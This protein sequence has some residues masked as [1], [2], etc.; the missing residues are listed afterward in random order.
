MIV[1]VLVG[2]HNLDIEWP[3]FFISMLVG[4]FGGGVLVLSNQQPEIKISARQGFILVLLCWILLPCYAALPF[5]F[6]SRGISLANSLFES[7]SGLTTTGTTIF[8]D[9]ESLS[10]ALL[11]W[12]AILQWLG[13]IGII[14]MAFTVMPALRI[15]GMQLFLDAV[16]KADK[17]GAQP[18]RQIRMLA[19]IYCA[20]TFLCALCYYLSGMGVFDAVS[21]AMTT[22]STGGFSNYNNSIAHFSNPFI[23]IT[24]LIFM[25]V[26]SLPFVL[27]IRALSGNPAGFWRDTQSLWFLG[28][29]AL[30]TLLIAIDIPGWT[31]NI[32]GAVHQAGFTTISFLS[33]TGFMISDYRVWSPATTAILFFMTFSGGC[34]GSTSGGIK[35]FRFQILYATVVTQMQKLLYPSG[36]FTPRFQGTA[37]TPAVS[38]SVL[39][40]FFAYTIS[41]VLLSC[42]LALTGLDA[43]TALSEAAAALSNAGTDLA[44][45]AGS[46]N[47]LLALDSG[48]RGLLIVGMIVGRLEVLTVLVL[49]SARFWRP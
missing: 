22:I 3:V 13:G 49:F 45:I 14:A 24:A 27:Y 7:V 25:I 10:P 28:F 11:I 4:I 20:L 30:G 21:H 34:S 18:S 26:G 47:S 48:E 32:L 15:G 43:M 42:L 46:D 6:S 16:S 33:G 37:L 8:I 17:G 19:E 1:P 9:V 23:E 35:I 5:W 29:C 36:I 38:I 41:F 44:P 39:G 40:F 31:G 12:R 2:L